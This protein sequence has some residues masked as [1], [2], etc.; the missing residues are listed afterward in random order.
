MNNIIRK[1]NHY[2]Y[3]RLLGLLLLLFLTSPWWAQAHGWSDGRYNIMKNHNVL[4]CEREYIA[5][6]MGASFQGLPSANEQ[7]LG[8]T[9]VVTITGN[10]VT[11]PYNGG[12]QFALGYTVS[13]PSGVNL[14]ESDI[15][16]ADAAKVGAIH[17]GTYSMGL[18][19]ASFGCFNE[20]Y[21]VVFEV[22]DGSLTITRSHLM[23]S[24]DNK[25]KLYGDSDP[26][27]TATLLGLFNNDEINYSLSR[28]A[29]ETVGEYAIT[30]TGD[31][32]QGDYILS[33]LPG[34]FS[35]LPAPLTI[36]IADSK[37]YD[38][39]ALQVAYN[40]AALSVA[41]L[42]EGDYLTAGAVV[43]N[44]SAVAVY[45]YPASVSITEAFNS[46]HGISNYALSY[47]INLEI[48]RSNALQFTNCNSLSQ[49]KNYDR[50]PLAP[51][52]IVNISEGT[53]LQYSVDNG[54]W[55]E[56]EAPSI[57]E[58]GQLSVNVR[59]V[60]PNYDTVYCA[61]TLSVAPTPL[62]LTI[63]GTSDVVD[64]DNISHTVA[65]YNISASSPYFVVDSDLVFLGM[66]IASRIDAGTS[67][68]GLT[69]EQFTLVNPNFSEVV[70]DI[71]DGYLTI[72]PIN[73][74][75]AIVG[76]SDTSAYDASAHTV[77]GFTASSASPLYDVNNDFVF[78]GNAM[79]SRV[80]AGTSYMGLATTQ[81]TNI[82]TNFDQVTFEIIDGYQ[83]ITPIYAEVIIVGHNNTAQFDGIVHSVNGYNLTVVT[84]LYSTNDFDFV[85][86]AQ[87]DR[88]DAGTTYMG[89]T[90]VQFVNHNSNFDTVSFTVTDGYQCI[91]PLDEVTV[92]IT[93][94]SDTVIYDGS[95]QTV[96]GYTATA[97]NSLYHVDSD[98]IFSGI[99]TA[100][101]TFVGTTNMGLTAE[102]FEN[103][104]DNFIQV[105][106]VVT[107]G[108]LTVMP[109][110]E[111]TV[112]IVGHTDTAVYDG[113]E[114]SVSGYTASASSSLYHVDSDFSFSGSDTAT[115]TF[116]GTSNMGLAAEQFA[117]LNE[118]FAS[119]IFE[120]TDGWQ[121]I[122]PVAEVVV[123][124]TGH[125]DTA[126]YDGTEHS[127]TGYTATASNSL[128]HVDTDF[129]FSGT[130]T[131]VRTFVG[132]T[133]MGL[134]AE[135]FM[136]LN[137]NFAH[138]TFEV[139]DG[140]L[141]I[142]PVAEIVV[143]ITGQTDTA[144]YDGT[145]HSVNGYTAVANNSLYHLDSDY[146]FSG[147]ATAMRTFVG[148]SNMGLAAEQFTNL[149][150][151]F[152]HVTFEVTDGGLTINPIAE[153]VVSITGHVDTVDFD[154]ME[155]LVNGYTAVANNSLYSVDNDFS[156]SGS[157]TAVRTYV[158]TSYMGLTAAQFA[159]TNENFAHVSFEV[160]DGW[161]TITQIADVVVT[162]TGHYSAVVYDGTS[163]SVSGYEVTIS[164]PLYAVSDFVFSGTAMADRTVAGTSYMGLTAE[165]F[166]NTNAN[167]ATVI[168]NV[169]DGYQTINPIDEVT[170]TITGH[171]DT[172]VYD[173]TAHVVSGYT[174]TASNSLYHV[175]SDFSF[176]GADT[177]VRTNVGT[178][179][180]GLA[181][182]Q[183]TNTNENF[184]QVNFV[185][186]D[187]WQT[188][189]PVAE[190]V[191]TIAGHTDTTVYDGTEHV[192]SSYTATANNSLYNLDSDYSFS[193]T[194][195]AARTFVGTT[196]MGLT[197]AQFTNTNENFAHVTFE[198]TDGWQ[199]ILPVAEVVV[200][201]TG[202]TNTV[203]Y[204]GTEHVVS[205]YTVTTNNNLYNLNSD[206][207]FSG[208]DTA[209]RTFVGTTNMGLV[210]TQ[211]ANLNENFAHVTFEVTDGWLTIN[212]VAEVVV[213]ITGH[214][215]TIVYDG[216][217]HVVTGYTA[218]AN[219]SLYNLDSDYS[220]SGTDTV[221]RTL[222]GTT[223][224]G[225][226]ANQF[227]N[228]NNNFAHVS[229]NVTDGWLTI[230]PV[231]EVVVTITGHR[232]TTVY[233]GAEHVVSGYTA[234][235]N[236][237]LYNL[238]SDYNFS[239]TAIAARTYIGTTNMGLNANQFANTNN[240]FAHV[241]FNVTDGGQMILPVA[242]VV[243]TITGQRDTS[244]YDGR[245]HI[246]VG[247][248]V[249]I[250]NPL[251][252]E[253]DFY[254][255]DIDM[256]TRTYVGTSFMGLVPEQFININDNFAHVTF[257]VIDGG[258][259]IL[260]VAEV[261]VTI[262]GQTSTIVYDGTEHVVSGYTATTNNSLYSLNSDYSFSGADTAV[263]TVVGTTNMGLAAEQFT[264][265]N[266]N[267]AQ[268]NFNVTDGWLTIAKANLAITINDAKNF[269]GTTLVTAY[270][271]PN[272]V[273]TEGLVAGD[274]LTAGEVES[275]GNEVA[276]Y[277]YP[278]SVRINEAFA[279]YKGIDN[280][281]VS[282]QIT[283]R[284]AR[285][286]ALEITNCDAL[287]KTG[288][289]NGLALTS[290]PAVNITT[291]TTLEYS[292]NGGAWS[293]SE[294]PGITNVGSIEVSV[295]AINPN[296]D[297][298]YC[299]YTLTVQPA[300]LTVTANDKNRVY[301]EANP[302]FDGIITGFANGEDVS[303]VSG[304]ATYSTT[305]IQSS[306]VGTYPIVP[307]ISML[308]AQN[309]TFSAVNGQ[310][311]V[312]PLAVVFTGET[313]SL[314]YNG[315]VQQ[316]T[317][318]SQ[319]GLV[320]GHSF[321]GLN[322]LAQG[323]HVGSYN[324]SF[325]GTLVISDALDEDVTENYVV[326]YVSGSLTITPMSG[327]TVAITG[328][329]STEVYNGTV[330]TVT[331]YD[332]SAST[333]IY[334]NSCIAFTGRDTASKKD[335]GTVYMG[336]E[337]SQF[338]NSSA[339][340][341]NVSFEVTDGYQTVTPITQPITIT[342]NSAY[343][344][345]DGTALTEAG[346]TYTNGILLAGDVLSA[347]VTGTLTNVDT[348]A[349]VVTAYQVTRGEEVI[350]SNYTFADPVA[351]SLGIY[352]RNVTLTS[353]SD[354]KV[355]DGTP[356]TNS[357]VTV[358]GDGF[359]ANE[360]ASYTVTGSQTEVGASQNTF[361]YSLNS[362]TLA[363][364]YTITTIEGT[365]TVTTLNSVVVTITGHSDTVA[366]D[367]TAHSV[368]GYEISTNNPLYSV[369]DVSFSGTA[370]ATG[371]QVGT[372]Y[373]GLTAS[374]FTNTN[375]N[376]NSVTFVVTDGWL[377]VSPIEVTV[378]ITGHHDTTAYNGSAQHV[379]GYEV[380]IANPLYSVN[381]I[382]FSG[383]ANATRT[384]VGTTYM[385]L[386]ANQFANTNPNFA[387]V[388]FEVTDGW[389]TVRP[390]NVTVAITGHHATATYD[391]TAHS[392]SGYE[393]SIANPLYTV[394]DISFSGTATASGTE[395]GTTYMGLTAGQFAN[396]NPNFAQVTFEV[397]DG[398]QT[399]TALSGVVVTITGHHDTTTYDAT[400][401]SVSGYTAT[402]NN[403]LYHVNSDFS[404]SGTAEAA[405]T[406]VG[407]SYMG[408]TAGQ[409]ANT[410][411]NFT[412]VTFE[413][414]DGWH[415][416]TPL[417]ISFVG[418]SQTLT[419]NGST[420]AIEGITPVGL[421]SG[422]SFEG[423][424]YK[425]E[426]L[427]VGT[428][429]G[430]FSGTLVV[431]DANEQNVTSNYTYTTT[432]GTLTI[433]HAS[434]PV[435][436]TGESNTMVY[437]GSAQT[438]TGIT[439]A[440]LLE[441]HTYTNLNYAATGTS[442][443]SYTG[444]FEGTVQ[445]WSGGVDVSE[446]YVV[447]ETPGSLEITTRD[448]TVS[449]ADRSLEYNG[450]EQL[451]NTACS[452]SNMVSGHTAT[453]T[454]TPSRGKLV[455]ATPYDNGEF[456]L[457]SLS[458]EDANGHN[459]SA[460]YNLAAAVTGKLTITNRTQK[461][462]ITVVA[463]SSTGNIYDGTAK[464]V[465]G[466]QS[467]S[468]EVEGNSYTVEGLTTSNPSSINVCNLA[469]A[470]TGTAVVRDAEQNI[471]TDQFTVNKLNGTLEIKAKAATIAVN[472]AQ[473]VYGASDPTF[474]GTVSGLVNEGDLGVV[475]FIRSN[476]DENVGTYNSVLTATYTTN[477][478][479]TVTIN[480]GRFTITRAIAVVTADHQV[481]T[482][483]DDD[484]VFT[485]TVTG[486]QRGDDP[487]IISYQLSRVEGENVGNYN[488]NAGGATAQGNYI[489]SYVHGT[490]TIERAF[491]S[492]NA[493]DKTKEYGDADPVLT[494]TL[495]GLKNGDNASV[496][497]YSLSREEGESMGEYTIT[498]TGNAVQGN[499][500]VYFVSGVMTITAASATVTANS[501]TKVYG[502]DDPAL[503]ATIT[504]LKNGDADSLIV[505]SL[506]RTAGENAGVYP[507][508]PSG[509]S[510]QGNYVVT[511][512]PSTMNITRAPV[513]LSLVSA[514]KVY[515]DPDPDMVIATGLKNG[516]D[517][518]VL[519]YNLSRSPN[520]ENVGM[521]T[522][523]LSIPVG[524]QN[525]YSVVRTTSYAYLTINQAPLTVKADDKV[526]I[527]SEAD[528][529]LTVSIIGLKNGDN[530]SVISYNGP[531]RAAGESV[532]S[533][534]ISVSGQGNQG[535]YTVSFQSGT[536]TIVSN[537]VS[538]TITG[539]TGSK[540]YNGYEQSVTGYSV[541]LPEGTELTESDI[542]CLRA[543]EAV[544]TNV[545]TYNMGLTAA[546]FANTNASY[547][548]N[549]IVT[550]GSM[551]INRAVARVLADNVTKAFGEADPPF[552]ATIVGLK[553]N[554][555]ASVLSYTFTRE[556]GEAV[557]TYVITP[558]GDQDQGNYRVN[559]YR[560]G[561]LT[562][563]A[564]WPDCPEL[565]ETGH[566]PATITDRTEVFQAVTP[567]YNVAQGVSVIDAYYT[568]TIP[569][570]ADVV[571]PAAYNNGSI[572]ADIN[573]PLEWRG[574]AITVI[575]TAIYNGCGNSTP[576][577][578]EPKKIC[579]P[580][581]IA[582]AIISTSNTSGEN[583]TDLFTNGGMV[584]LRA[585]ISN[586]DDSKIAEYGFLISTNAAEVD[587]YNS[588]V[589]KV[590]TDVTSDT[591]SYNI[592]LD[593]CM[594]HLYYKPY[595]KLKDCDSTIV[596]GQRR[597]FSM[598]HPDLQPLTV[599]PST[600]VAQ[601]T[602][603]TLSAVANMTV[604]SWPQLYDR[605]Y[606]VLNDGATW[607]GYSGCTL[608]TNGNITKTMEEWMHILLDCQVAAIMVDENMHLNVNDASFRYEWEP[609]GWS[610]PAPQSHGVTT[611][612]INQ[613][614]T[615]QGSAIFTYRGME[616][617]VSSN[618]TVTV[619]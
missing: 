406:D 408:L 292:V 372:T 237:S 22:T 533:Y 564:E 607:H 238:D 481:K 261:T 391:G 134:A 351:G 247:Y 336:L 72:L 39:N 314:T 273:T 588:A 55:T 377:T 519:S 348:V 379:S 438:I 13:I 51:Q 434:I 244:I 497:S 102:Q 321:S 515:G 398:Y 8:D 523:T 339:D 320:S 249:E 597:D 606:H 282:Y 160:T 242:E 471:V 425:A 501:Q 285:N 259:T 126:V 352:R 84:P 324:G 486:M 527:Y 312:Q 566:V 602:A 550:D 62:T 331:G 418:E 529:A 146:S 614:T 511:Y 222:V 67:Y 355:Y 585:I 138:V 301:Y 520:D 179:N 29:G 426:G 42:V 337:A 557:G 580:Y 516:D 365:L 150:E 256:A 48:Q 140:W 451:G 508:T 319:S 200:T 399:I 423:L 108:W 362:N 330:R 491:L 99:D 4:L 493:D 338:A 479:Y 98:F 400:A 616:C 272:V 257:N 194:A 26:E 384:E 155:H 210:A 303:V 475:S 298:T 35:V 499:Y 271:T 484:P 605:Y 542:V 120:V 510:V 60:N 326:S 376:F 227:V 369:N 49:S 118:N 389:L 7:N 427:N 522:V 503:T 396:T 105:N 446:N 488:I 547:L 246:V 93:G 274:Y 431:K 452:F 135:Q 361:T 14:S 169:T 89:L 470:I 600:S 90:D 603:I 409:F 79:V 456:T 213:T 59:A 347:T 77:M 449:V 131:A 420:Q 267:F 595:L 344:K 385:G 574:K 604:G 308:S 598:W 174:A 386:S 250:D 16:C 538:V 270:N 328:H 360:G 424:S 539:N 584:I 540:T 151:N 611:T 38:G 283:Q 429:Q 444:V 534:T 428:Y 264:N 28:V 162:I 268:V 305:A 482:Y 577:V 215:E 578:G 220:F 587:S 255:D 441:G 310:L 178:T 496:I 46:Q 405:R 97:S 189:L 112:N 136:N 553:G 327:V 149:N 266:E 393:V 190:V 143:T 109:F 128:Y 52:P 448:I 581:D 154:G 83:M 417:A 565:G 206:Y 394:N 582:P 288:T 535:N 187:G 73:V 317:A 291:G 514:S 374:Q 323:I 241:T 512:V 139:T 61:Y 381:D 504:G 601:G 531:T 599:T 465:S 454:Y 474:T 315:A 191:V 65:G 335:V 111:V 57:T 551:T 168:F 260:P 356:L 318:I 219:N 258:Q 199:T 185:V 81:F 286:D 358:G 478:N 555:D 64:Y 586:R 211:F 556:P 403:S 231:A 500:N 201:I 87:A 440:G 345:Y 612:T 121:T 299:S 609:I 212:P 1:G 373:M 477:A 148:T 342:A 596:Y 571:V 195:I 193:G 300:E 230:N 521:K 414:N 563:I 232:D 36:T 450:S 560:T 350:T 82:N 17:V 113:T 86:V 40:S 96:T 181:A 75:V 132:T 407:T 495:Y 487:S 530:E 411:L 341:T 253:D 251:Y 68:M 30:A 224:M 413:I 25:S 302:D 157:D 380:S 445:I 172:A 546:D 223:S 186:T 388:T 114:H 436:F 95:E 115:R 458:V 460:N 229:F 610:S 263:R 269:D 182:A 43:S 188:I 56:G 209:V 226:A 91:T 69:A 364:N 311:T 254:F 463:N 70:F 214:T 175:D 116:V 498:G 107:D 412:D 265:T 442:V 617:K 480:R 579:V 576:F 343:K 76:N 234:T 31:S 205:G 421:V 382:S 245:L 549:F 525:N 416:V 37:T 124:I 363:G 243:V 583:K 334:T 517:L 19:A 180:M 590:L 33:F 100:K 53:V 469:N 156:F 346:Y 613:T 415:T 216:T 18:T 375:P 489:V 562:I 594:K 127:V 570:M 196:N 287:T 457:S 80:D 217:E 309:Y 133:N 153:V 11:T 467:L 183:F 464:S 554:D 20:D 526:K 528:P 483:G 117:N 537:P 422:H 552:T 225:L 476:T 524:T 50:M 12:T 397:T 142:N 507:I 166:T 137:E 202:H 437:N 340:F 472:N 461:Y 103:I 390:I 275:F 316:S 204:D 130:D 618:I 392:V 290:V 404:F 619:Q 171:T 221:V 152:A 453:I 473:K 88:M 47:D 129:S 532:G 378:A 125:V 494:A 164:N 277:V 119:V 443:G 401:H 419:Y 558:Q 313:T 10:V 447:T 145:E 490:L 170:V 505:Y 34:T 6:I 572:T 167:Y 94:H 101:R 165:Q 159:N 71:T 228:T 368:S 353:A 439:S 349:N 58:V 545:G 85:G 573:I 332:M 24:A 262:T 306:S 21:H 294:V 78:S 395:V 177:A 2:R 280:Y 147:T 207:S 366:Y 106:F 325:S 45:T 559:Q 252:T 161:L 240:N 433:S 543:A 3:G 548:V 333:P 593:S 295:R 144:V 289:Y 359:V 66:A 284:I 141:T 430:A 509:N 279:T 435:T 371:T 173:G 248:E 239:G 432:P 513:T 203:V 32:L 402:A 163:H 276:T 357:E 296:Y 74:T 367:G 544:G 192:V 176:S 236:N 158:G 278:A 459:V 561:L 354:S 575:L 104:S 569:G 383:T 492:L 235:S 184:A 568:I 15:V 329:H 218:M 110:P 518:S 304:N 410:N 370:T 322:Y 387:D 506:S 589:A 468:F 307:D 92:T 197:A 462:Q 27:L 293:S 41:G 122:S 591:I 198:V 54:E 567:V 541:T 63:V 466:F 592:A 502:E 297:T 44:A 23:V 9:V 455:S 608:G 5:D 536:F 485:A 233:D 615:Y 208:T 123:T 281:Q